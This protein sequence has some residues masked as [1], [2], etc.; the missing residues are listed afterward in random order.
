MMV[1]KSADG[2]FHQIADQA[3]PERA[4]S[5]VTVAWADIFR[6]YL[7]M[8]QWLAFY[9][10][11]DPRHDILIQTTSELTSLILGRIVIDQ[12]SIE[13]LLINPETNVVKDG[14]TDTSVFTITAELTE[15]G[16]FLH[17]VTDDAGR[18]Q[19]IVEFE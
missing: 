19:Q 8:V 16:F 10:Q 12:S 7:D 14:S 2:F 18:V 13:N 6:R 4:G 15:E 17:T 11:H 5:I 3:D 1:A 9:E